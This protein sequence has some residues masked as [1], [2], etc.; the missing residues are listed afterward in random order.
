M[1]VADTLS[2]ALKQVTIEVA[3][4]LNGEPRSVVTDITV[5]VS[6]PETASSSAAFFGLDN[7][8][9]GGSP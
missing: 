4:I 9:D 2:P 6:N 3:P 7:S 1:S 5:I 8:D